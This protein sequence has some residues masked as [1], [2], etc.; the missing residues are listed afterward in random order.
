VYKSKRDTLI[1]NAISVIAIKALIVIIALLKWDKHM[2]NYS[3]FVPD[4]PVPIRAKIWKIKTLVPYRSDLRVFKMDE[5]S[6][7]LTRESRDEILEKC[8]KILDFDKKKNSQFWFLACWDM[9]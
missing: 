3:S 1:K 4:A 6:K 2:E 5:I 8:S 7:N 9:P